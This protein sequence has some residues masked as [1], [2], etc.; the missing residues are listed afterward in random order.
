MSSILDKKRKKQEQEQGKAQ[1]QDQ[2]RI[3]R[4]S[5]FGVVPRIVTLINLIGPLNPILILYLCN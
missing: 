1:I 4:F 5:R 2:N 3:Q